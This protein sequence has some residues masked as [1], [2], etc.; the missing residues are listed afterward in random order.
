MFFAQYALKINQLRQL[1][2]ICL[3]QDDLSPEPGRRPGI[4]HI[5]I[6]FF[7]IKARFSS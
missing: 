7:L 1:V 2:I 4:N 5:Q 3:E 6:G